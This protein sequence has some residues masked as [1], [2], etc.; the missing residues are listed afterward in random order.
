M[1]GLAG[2]FGHIAPTGSAE[3]YASD[4]DV[5]KAWVE[6]IHRYLASTLGLIVVVIAALSIRARREPGVSVA[7]SLVL[8]ILVVLQGM[9][10]MLTVTWLL[11]PLI[12]TA[13]LMGGLTTFALLLWLWLSMRSGSA[14]SGWIFRARRQYGRGGRW[15]VRACGRDLHWPASPCRWR[16]VA[17]P[18][19]TTRRSHAR[20]CPGARTSGYPEADFKNAFVLWRGHGINYAGGALEHPGTRGHSFHASR[21]RGARRDLVAAGGL[22]RAFADSDA[23]H[24]G[25]RWQCWRPWPRR[26]P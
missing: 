16:S 18:A 26:F 15:T 22:L 11:K 9:L 10:G 21:G 17:G 20:T 24:A 14:R 7:F 25:R 13:H 1:P 2:C 3:H 4:A 19:A 23:G 5:R 8:L 6:M 12:V